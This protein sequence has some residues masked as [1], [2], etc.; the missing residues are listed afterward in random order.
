MTEE[1]IL[2]IDYGEKR[3]GLAI[4]DPMKIIAFPLTSFANDK[5][6]WSMFQKIFDEYPISEI[7]LGY[8]LKESGGKSEITE[9]VEKFREELKKR[10]KAE[11]VFFDERYTSKIASQ[12]ILES[13]TSKKKRK[14]KSRI[15]EQ[16]A[17]IL[18]QDY[19]NRRK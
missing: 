9:S 13:V 5:N 15:D 8:P 14:E 19:L 2:A 7:A 6:L 4:T 16:A 17:L 12:R 18:L 11:I 10:T 1:R 3:I